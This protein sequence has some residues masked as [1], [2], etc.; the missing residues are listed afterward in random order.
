MVSALMYRQEGAQLEF[1]LAAEIDILSERL[2]ERDFGDVDRTTILRAIL[3]NLDEDIY[4]TD[5][6]RLTSGRRNELLPKLRSGVKRTN[7]SLDGAVGFLENI[8][9]HTSRLLPYTMQLV[10]ISA[11]LDK[12]PQPSE[13]HR[14]LLR[15][16]FWASSFSGWFGGANTSRVNSLVAE[17]RRIA[18]GG[19]PDRLENFD[20]GA[21]ALPFPAKFD[22]RSA[23]T[24]TLLLVMLPC[25]HANQLGG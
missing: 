6:T 7:E 14:Q 23:R 9:I 10:I 25:A 17:F 18:L 19:V 2:G 22:M 12:M 3:A 13:E 4:R 21:M 5:W 1:D 16:W 11:F 15:R 8:G 24:R 20:L